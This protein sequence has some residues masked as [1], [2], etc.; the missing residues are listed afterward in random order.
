MIG[1]YYQADSIIHRLDPRVKLLGTLLFVLSL[2]FPKNPEN[3]ILSTAFLGL[4][5]FLSKVPPGKMLKG[6]RPILFII[7]FSVAVN[8]FCTQGHEILNIG[9]LSVTSEGLWTAFYLAVRLIYLIIGSSVMTLTTTPKQLTDGMEQSLNFLKRMH[10]PVHE[11][12]MMMSIALRFIPILSE[13]LNKIKKAQMARG[14]DFETGGLIERGK[15]L[16][17]VLVPLFIAAVRRA[18]DLA[19]AMDARCYHGG[20][21]KTKLHP[22]R[23][24]RRDYV[25]C[26]F[27]FLYMILMAA[28]AFLLF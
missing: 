18:S 14:I 21:G 9:P 6:I 4:I 15:K 7:L 3:L 28:F 19:F 22:L 5:I 20:E 10:V 11:F 24:E 25:A 13:E 8:L 17:P 16:I 27:L 12:S 23:Y 1:Q 2:F 26:G